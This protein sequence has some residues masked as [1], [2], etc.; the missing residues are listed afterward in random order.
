[1][2]YCSKCGK[3][4]VDEA[5]VCPGCGCAQ[6]NMLKRQDDARNSG[7][8]LVGFCIPIVGLILYLVWKDDMPLRA[9][10][11]G[12]GALISVIAVPAFYI[13]MVFIAVLSSAVAYGL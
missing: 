13:L 5:V 11:V 4:L 3:E 6:G 8:A 7:W 10:S 12:K 1:M 9:K 2:K